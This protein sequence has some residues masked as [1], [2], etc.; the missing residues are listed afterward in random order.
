MQADQ[1][2]RG[3][4]YRVSEVQDVVASL[5]PI[6]LESVGGGSV[7]LGDLWRDQHAI[8]VWLRHYG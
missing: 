6:E 1:V 8:L 2:Q 5:E 4:P 3:V 7:R